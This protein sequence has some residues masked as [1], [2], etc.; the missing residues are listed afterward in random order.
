MGVAGSRILWGGM[1]MH[2]LL[3][4]LSALALALPLVAQVTVTTTMT[5]AQLV[6]NVLLGP[7]VVA[8]NITYNG[9]PSPLTPQVGS[10]TFNVVNANLGINAGVVLS[11]GFITT[12]PQNPAVNSSD[13]TNTGGDADLT[14]LSGQ[15]MQDR[16]VLEFDFIPVG[17][18]IKFNYVFASE[19]YPTFVCT[20]FNDAFGF[21]LSGPGIN[22]PYSNNA[23][24]IALVPGT[25]LPV[26]INSINNG[27]P[28]NPN[29]VPSNPQY[30]VNN[31]GNASPVYNAFTTVLRAE[32]AVQCGETYHIKLAIADAVDQSWDS[33]VFLEAGSFQSNQ[34]AIAGAV[35]SGGIDSLFYEGCG[36]AIIHLV[37]GGPLLTT[38]T[39]QIIPGGS[40]TMGVDYTPVPSPVI[41]QPGQDSITITISAILDMITEGQENI[42]LMVINQSSCGN[43]TV[44][45]EFFIEEAPLIDLVMSPDATRQC[46]DSVWVGATV[47]GGFGNYQLIWDQGIANG[48][49]G[50]WVVPA[51]TT[52]YTLTVTDDCGV[53]TR[54]GSVTITVPILSPLKVL[55]QPDLPVPCPETPIQLQAVVQGGTPAYAYLWSGG[56]GTAPSAWVAPPTTHSWW[57]TV[58]DLCG[59]QV[60]DTVTITVL[61]DSIRVAIA[62]DTV[63]CPGDTIT[64]YA[65][66]ERG[67]GAYV[68]AWSDGGT[69]DTLAVYPQQTSLYRLTVTDACGIADSAEVIV[70]VSRPYADMT[71]QGNLHE[72]NFPIEF[73]D[74]SVG[75]HTWSWDFGYPGLVSTDPY[76]TVTYPEPGGYTVQLAITDTLGCR[77]T[78]ERVIWVDPEF[79]LYVPNTFTPDGDGFNEQ[80]RA[81][82]VGIREFRMRVF[83]RWGAL[84]FVSENL[85]EG[86]DGSLGGMPAST[87]VYVYHIRVKALSGRTRE[88]RGH[89][90]LLR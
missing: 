10:G 44:L 63:I 65:L 22:G 26:A 59:D 55:A 27:N 50:A 21:F 52:T 85:D 74:L 77:D 34:V 4:G 28:N 78:V 36:E 80:F 54:T 32:A 71:W 43:D 79:Q 1:G 56:L 31:Q 87:G 61:Y 83:D 68:Y 81:A 69:A 38:D 73:V 9:I 39:V 72:N 82:G 17:D 15:A 76:P 6:Q 16:A 49:L 12:I 88:L 18:S 5:P 51:Q 2:R 48:S 67:H 86:W 3:S 33:A 23:V 57:V 84:V 14:L 20:N 46:D 70:G 30:Y 13:L 45:V 47:S 75:A 8:S 19:E 24:N 62:P 66:A 25:T 64:L 60:T 89:V 11:S 53:I 37:R 42:L 58:T 7:G 35:V 90:T 40:A 41:F 29:C